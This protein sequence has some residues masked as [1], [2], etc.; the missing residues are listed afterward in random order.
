MPVFPFYLLV[1]GEPEA[2]QII[3]HR[4]PQALNAA[5]ALVS[6]RQI[7]WHVDACSSSHGVMNAFHSQPV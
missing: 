3:Y 4:Q 6:W 5:A 7:Y 1:L 2:T